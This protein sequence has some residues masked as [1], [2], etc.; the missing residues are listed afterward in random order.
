MRPVV[1]V[2]MITASTLTALGDELDVWSGP[3]PDKTFL[4][5]QR[6]VPETDLVQRTDLDGT[7]VVIS[8]LDHSGVISA[9]YAQHDFPGRLITNIQWSPDSKFLLFTT[10]SSG[11][12][13]PWHL[14]GRVESG[15]K[16]P[17][18]FVFQK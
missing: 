10:A 11:G 9:V 17:N 4:A 8:S 3:S 2:A 6:R 1:L 16:A 12:Y 18:C 7:R 13:S 15:Q 5:A 14:L